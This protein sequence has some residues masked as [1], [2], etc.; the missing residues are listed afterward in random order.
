LLKYKLRVIPVK[1]GIQKNNGVRLSLERCF[2][3]PVILKLP[4]PRAAGRVGRDSN[5]AIAAGGFGNPPY[6]VNY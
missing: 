1:A 2:I 3:N 6:A 4:F 5:P